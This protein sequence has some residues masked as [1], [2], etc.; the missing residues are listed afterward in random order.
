MRQANP[1]KTKNAR[2]LVRRTCH[3]GRPCSCFWFGYER[4]TWCK[5]QQLRRLAPIPASKSG[6]SLVARAVILSLICRP[7][8]YAVDC[9]V[10]RVAVRC[11]AVRCGAANITACTLIANPVVDSLLISID[12]ASAHSVHCRV[13]TC[14]SLWTRKV[15]IMALTRVLPLTSWLPPL[16]VSNHHQRPGKTSGHGDISSSVSGPS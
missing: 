15:S 10:R 14:L 9:E 1:N 16:L 2:L 6:S 7:I 8:R 13:S 3:D 5:V 12:I 11:A 4:A